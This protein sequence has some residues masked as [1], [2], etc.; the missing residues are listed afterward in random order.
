MA[1]EVAGRWGAK[2]KKPA[3][4][5]AGTTVTAEKGDPKV[6]GSRRGS[7]VLVRGTGR[8]YPP[9]VCSRKFQH[10]RKY[11]AAKSRTETWKTK[12]RV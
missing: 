10:K 9:A 6:K 1:N 5:K 11:S 2:E 3:A 4:R 7:A 12:G 8:Y